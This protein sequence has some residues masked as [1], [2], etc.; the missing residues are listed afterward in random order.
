MALSVT[1][2]NNDPS[3]G[4]NSHLAVSRDYS[5]PE[6]I[7]HLLSERAPVNGELKIFELILNLSI[8]HGSETLSAKATIAAGQTG[9]SISQAVAAG[10]NQINETHGGAQELCM[11]I[12]YRMVKEQISPVEIV[13]ECLKRQARLSGFGHRLYQ[14]LDARAELILTVLEQEGLG[15]DFIAAAR[16]LATELSSQSGKTLPLNI[17]GAIAVALCAFGWPV[18]LGQAVFIIARTPGLCGQYLNHQK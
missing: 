5:F 6:M 15:H 7:F 13:R 12:L 3:F 2:K 8:D 18:A 16:K 10:V 9:K 11:P 1:H 17:D 4:G 14:R